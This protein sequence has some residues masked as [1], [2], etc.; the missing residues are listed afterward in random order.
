[1]AKLKL[2]ANPTFKATVGIPVAGGDPVPVEMTFKHRTKTALD[3]FIKTRPDKTDSETF[4]DMV[5]GWDLED[6][7]NAASV[8]TLLENYAGAG[9]ATFRVYID[10]LIQAKLKN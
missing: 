5:V 7:F 8:D 3:E 9:L 2:V 4:T 1:M 10:Q 6:T